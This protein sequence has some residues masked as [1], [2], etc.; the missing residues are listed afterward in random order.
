[1][2]ESKMQNMKAQVSPKK[3]DRDYEDNEFNWGGKPTSPDRKTR[4]QAA[5]FGAMTKFQQH[6]WKQ[7]ADEDERKRRERSESRQAERQR[8]L[9]IE[10][11]RQEELA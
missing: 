4:S 2:L 1:M 8:R 7:T 5:M 9:E 10:R 3:P 6:D 11:R